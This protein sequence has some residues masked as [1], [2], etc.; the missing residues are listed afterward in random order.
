ML[1]YEPHCAIE[2]A[3]SAGSVLLDVTVTHAAFRAVGGTAFASAMKVRERVKLLLG[4]DPTKIATSLCCDDNATRG[5][6]GGGGGGGEQL[7]A[8]ERTCRASS[9]DLARLRREVASLQAES[10][11]QLSIVHGLVAA[12]QA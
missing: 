12:G 6:G 5:G 2:L 11:E 3:V 7:V 9:A 8:A 4:L 10:D 1:C